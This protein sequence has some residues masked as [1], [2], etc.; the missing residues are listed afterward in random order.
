MSKYAPLV[1]HLKESE[2]DSVAMTFKEVEAVIGAPLP[3]SAYDESL[4]WW[5]NDKTHVQAFSWMNA[6][7]RKSD[8]DVRQETVAF[9]RHGVPLTSVAGHP[10]H[11]AKA[12][13]RRAGRRR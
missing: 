9:C 11:G 7:W 6:G 4:P 1:A 2:R 8:V 12:S 3:P 5:S 13:R 10:D